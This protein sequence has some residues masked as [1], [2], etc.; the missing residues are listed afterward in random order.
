MITSPA[1]SAKRRITGIKPIKIHQTLP[2]RPQFGHV[3]LRCCRLIMAHQENIK[4]SRHT[5]RQSRP[6]QDN[7]P[8]FASTRNQ[9][10]PAGVPAAGTDLSRQVR[11][12]R[13]SH[14]SAVMGLVMHIHA[15]DDVCADVSVHVLTCWACGA[16]PSAAISCC[17]IMSGIFMFMTHTKPSGRYQVPMARHR[18]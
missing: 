14:G 9:S 2:A 3:V 4:I 8:C 17:Y 1:S 7:S 6:I 15:V 5:S 11:N 13:K 10:G 16:S 12:I 18:P